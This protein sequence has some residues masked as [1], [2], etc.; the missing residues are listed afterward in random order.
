MRVYYT[1]VQG[2][3]NLKIIKGTGKRI[4]WAKGRDRQTVANGFEHVNTS[5]E[6]VKAGVGKDT[7]LSTSAD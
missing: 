5:G 6:L 7:I 4:T 2:R 3:P 1:P